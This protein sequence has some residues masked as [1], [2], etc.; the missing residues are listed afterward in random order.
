MLDMIIDLWITSG[1]AQLTLGHIVMI[2][3]ACILLYLG[4][5]KG[6][7]PYL[8]IPIAF[9][10]LLVNL[11]GV[12]LMVA[13]T[14][15]SPGGLFYY[16]YQGVQL[17]IFP[18]LIFLCIG[19][20]IDFGPLIAN[21]KTLLLGGAAQFGIF[22]AFLLAVAFNFTGPEAASIG[23]IGGADGPTTV[24][25]AG[26]LAPHLLSQIALAAYSYMALVPVIQ[27]PIIKLLTTKKERQI[28]MEQLRE[29]SKKE[30]ILYPVIVSIIVILL[31]PTSATLV[32]TLMLGNLLK[33]SG[34]VPLIVNA[35]KDSLMYV[36]TI[37][38]G[39]AIGATASAELFL[40]VEVIKIVTLGLVAF[41]I[42]TGAGVIGGKLLCKLSGGKINPI[43]GAAGVSAMPFAA[44]VVQ[45]IGQEENP[46]NFLLMH[47]M[48]PNVSGIIASAIAAGLFIQY[49]AG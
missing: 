18:P 34:K 30:K 15:N 11:P 14:D 40:T 37:A 20:N 7:E 3:I 33:E 16:L 29:V 36:L 35:L 12:D 24:F 46:N 17:V 42:G 23:I 5:E 32:G 41:A 27:P 6:M 1:F 19:V 25:L 13:P 21:P 4:L 43:I 28:K 26:Q 39:L 31:V 8:M 47:A 44:R 48:G 2:I 38:I 22:A 10:M 45:K 9:G 49:F